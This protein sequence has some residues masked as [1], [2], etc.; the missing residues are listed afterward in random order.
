MLKKRKHLN[1][2]AVKWMLEEV[3]L[4]KQPDLWL[5][6][7]L[8]SSKYFFICGKNDTYYRKLYSAL[9]QKKVIQD[10]SHAV[11]LEK[12]QRCYQVILKHLIKSKGL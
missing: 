11:H 8:S 1:A 12:P 2:S 3:S 10:C 6:L 7:N 5:H 4:L 9:S